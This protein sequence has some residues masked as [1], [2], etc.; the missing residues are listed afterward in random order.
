MGD[1]LFELNKIQLDRS[2]DG[3]KNYFAFAYQYKYGDLAWFNG[4]QYPY[5]DLYSFAD[6]QPAILFIFKCLRLIGIDITGHELLIVQSLPVVGLGLSA[7][8]LHKIMRIYDQPVLWTVITVTACLALSPQLFRFNSHFALAYVFCFPS[9]WYLLILKENQKLNTYLFVLFSSIL[10]LIYGFIHPYHLLICSIFL[11]AFGVVK[12]LFKKWDWTSFISGILPVVF[13]LFVNGTLDTY[14]DRTANPWGS[15]HYKTEISDMLPFYGWISYAFN[16]TLSLR[17]NYHEGYS[18]LGIL[19]FVVPVLW[20][21]NKI[22]QI[23]VTFNKPLL[24]YT[25]SAFFVLLFSMGLH[26]LLTNQQINEW[27][28]TLKQFRALG[29]FS[30]PFYYVTFIALSIYIGNYIKT[31]KYNNISYVFLGFIILFWSFDIYAYSRFFNKMVNN[32]RAPNELYTNTYLIDAL[33]D[34][35]KLDNFQAVLP[36]P[37]PTEGAE[38]FSPQDNWFV[39]TETMPF[40]FQTGIPL[41][42]GYMSRMSQSRILNQ[43]QLSNSDYVKKD[44]IDAFKNEKDLLVV[45]HKTDTTLFNNIIAKSYLIGQTKENMIYGL[46]VEALRKIKTID[47]PTNVSPAVYYNDF[48]ENQDEGLLSSGVITVNEPTVICELHSDTYGGRIFDFSI[49][50]RIDVDKSNAPVFSIKTFDTEG[51]EMSAIDYSDK[52]VKR[53]EVIGKWVQLK[54]THPIP[55]NTSKIRWSVNAEH[56]VLDHALITRQQDTFYRPLNDG[57]VMFNHFIGMGN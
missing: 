14:N 13:F 27:I 50:Y 45:V 24:K 46:T 32:Y 17:Q 39:K 18:Y 49:W 5:G 54:M 47:V 36:L 16:H 33:P 11:L 55:L 38:K 42:G 29:R 12:L 15:W 57:I 43:F 26:M 40:A 53:M 7:F 2:G 35:I 34:S 37:V 48:E 6:G 4:M 56:L 25:L 9:I 19:M 8:F 52:S 10:I 51:K 22:S 28:P 30:W 41:V 21:Y 1:I 31:L 20:L 44:A 3:F 23:N